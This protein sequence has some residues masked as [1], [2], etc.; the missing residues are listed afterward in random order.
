MRALREDA[1]ALVRQR[2]C[3]AGAE[4]GLHDVTSQIRAA[5]L[6][7]QVAVINSDP[8]DRRPPLA[9]LPEPLDNLLWPARLL[10]DPVPRGL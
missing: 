7:Q 1:D 3:K 2:M 8:G 6:G 9:V 4:V 10:V 5:Q